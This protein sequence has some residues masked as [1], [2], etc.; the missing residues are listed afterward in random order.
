[1][2]LAAPPPGRGDARPG[3]PRARGGRDDV[4][5]PR[6]GPGPARRLGRRYSNEEPPP[7]LRRDSVHL[8]P[9]VG[10][11]RSSRFRGLRVVSSTDCGLEG[12]LQEPGRA[13]GGRLREK[14]FPCVP[15]LPRGLRTLSSRLRAPGF[16]LRLTLP[17]RSAVRR[18]QAHTAY[19]LRANPP[20]EAIAHIIRSLL[21][22][23]TLR[24]P[25]GLV[26]LGKAP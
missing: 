25:E 15:L 13:S 14:P 7:V 6:S 1:M 3:R 16:L 10:A 9:Q 21:E 17:K 11:G 8:R 24:S 5:T 26:S 18:P 4:T 19:D 22:R 2:P 20:K 23:T 12:A